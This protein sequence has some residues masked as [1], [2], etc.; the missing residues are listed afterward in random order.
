MFCPRCKLEY[1]EGIKVC[2]DCKTALVDNLTESENDADFT[3][4]YYNTDE[5]RFEDE[6]LSQDCACPV[7]QNEV[8][9]EIIETLKKK[10]LSDEE[11]GLILENIRHSGG[12][13]KANYKPMDEKYEE[14]RS[15]SVVLIACGLIGIVFLLLNTFGVISLPLSGYSLWLTTIVMGILFLIFLGSG[16]RSFITA[17]KLAPEVD[18]E[19]ENIKKLVSFLKDEK[20]KGRFDL[21]N[22]DLSMEEASLVYSN[23]AVS[24]CEKEFTDLPEGFA[25]Y[26]T[27]RYYSEIFESDRDTDES[28][29]K[30]E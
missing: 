9:N 21:N 2:P 24:A 11:I 29:E 5:A 18:K 10:G 17:R 25:F 16:I 7:D 13:K 8:F 3:A 22:D 30:T 4:E 26:V 1:V 6:E 19:K 28:L 23:M 20:A 15:G 27:D 12:E 14:N